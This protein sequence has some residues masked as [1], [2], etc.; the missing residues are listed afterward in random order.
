MQS[1]PSFNN[2]SNSFFQPPPPPPGF[3]FTPTANTIP[4][5]APT[6]IKRPRAPP[7]L[8]LGDQRKEET[9]IIGAADEPPK[10]KSTNVSRYAVDTSH[11]KAK[12][13][14]KEKQLEQLKIDMDKRLDELRRDFKEEKEEYRK[15]INDLEH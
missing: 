7:I 3:P 2:N 9:S 11:W 10:K 5:A 14:E 1:Q 15:R 6:K 8:P 4:H 13:E 12:A